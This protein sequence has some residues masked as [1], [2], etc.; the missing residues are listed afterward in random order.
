MKTYFY[1]ALAVALG[2][3]LGS[4]TSDD[5]VMGDEMEGTTSITFRVKGMQ[6]DV[7]DTRASL[8]DAF[9]MMEL[10]LYTINDDGTY[11]KYREIDQTSSSATFGVMT[12][13]NVKCGKYRLVCIGHND[14]Q[15]PDIDDPT[16]VAFTNYPNAYLF[17][18][19][20]VLAQSTTS[21]DVP[22]A[23]ASARIRFDLQG[24]IPEE[25]KGIQFTLDGVS[26]NLN[27]ITGYAKSTTTR[28]ATGNVSETSRANKLFSTAV[29]TFLTQDELSATDSY[30]TVSIAGL[31]ESSNPVD[32]K[33]YEKVPLKIGYLTT[34]TGVFF[35]Y[36][37]TGVNFSVNSSW[38]DY[39][40]V[41]L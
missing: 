14:S 38:S 27:A 32:S 4:C 7:S 19:D 37:S 2:G 40:N 13:E 12:L 31:D 30:V 39:V 15:H 28:V 22:M 24:Y 10:A 23:H 35:D 20:V 17:S 5:K 26:A 8:G 34:F 41:S 16:D 25:V 36:N 1:A 29:Y 9:P 33:T 21:I 11:T 3:L 18:Q 6:I